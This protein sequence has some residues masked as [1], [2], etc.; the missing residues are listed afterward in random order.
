[1]NSLEGSCNL[2]LWQEGSGTSL[3]A[4]IGGGDAVNWAATPTAVFGGSVPKT[5]FTSEDSGALLFRSRGKFTEYDNEGI[6]QLYRFAVGEP[7]LKC[8]SCPPGGEAPKEGV[9]LGSLKF[10]G[11]APQD[12]ASVSS[13]NLSADGQRAFFETTEALVPADTNGQAGCPVAGS[14]TQFY[15]ACVDVYE[16]QAPGSGQCKESGPAYNLLNGGCLYLISTGKSKFPSLF[17]DASQSGEDVFFFTRQQLVGQDKDELQ[18]VYD[19]RV[20]GGLASQNPVFL[21][22][23]DSAETCHGPSP[24]PPVQESAG[25]AT[26]VGP[27][28]PVPKHKKP[29]AKKHKAKHKKA[30]HKQKRAGAER[31][32][33]R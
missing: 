7:G 4:R 32:A 28:N 15:S 22:P 21:P 23:C 6:G 10:P 26:F 29:K 27:G 16:W 3:V 5:S 1:M 13:R 25:T 30:K 9:S 17:A 19:A 14:P 12:G 18:D 20:K 8:V 24:S 2:Y 31:R 11:L 33:S